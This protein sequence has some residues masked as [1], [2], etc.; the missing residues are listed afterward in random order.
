V[1]S[2]G[3]NENHQELMMPYDGYICVGANW[4]YWLQLH[5][6]WFGCD[7]FNF[8]RICKHLLV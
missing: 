7:A 6:V 5:G 3:F 4:L 8:E 2:S 1:L